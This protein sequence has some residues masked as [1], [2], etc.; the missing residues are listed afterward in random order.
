MERNSSVFGTFSMIEGRFSASQPVSSGHASGRLLDRSSIVVSWPTDRCSPLVTASCTETRFR[1]FPLLPLPSGH[2]PLMSS[3]SR[4]SKHHSPPYSPL[5]FTSSSSIHASSAPPSD[6]PPCRSRT[7]CL[8]FS[9]L[10]SVLG[11][12]CVGAGLESSVRKQRCGMNRWVETGS[13]AEVVVLGGLSG[14]VEVV[15]LVTLVEAWLPVG[16]AV[17]DWLVWSMDVG[18]G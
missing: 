6:S 9:L 5:N 17:V 13:V 7:L 18:R 8:A 2:L 15:S 3:L 4:R 14:C 11:Y 10:G 1:F 16:F 12:G